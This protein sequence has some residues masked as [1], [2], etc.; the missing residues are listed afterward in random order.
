MSDEVDHL[1]FVANR[2]DMAEGTRFKP[3]KNPGLAILYWLNRDFLIM[4]LRHAV[5]YQA[6]W[7]LSGG[8]LLK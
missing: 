6:H 2:K 7:A 3:Q 5:I 8:S 4:H 1:W